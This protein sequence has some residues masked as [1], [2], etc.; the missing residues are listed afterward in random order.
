M[1]EVEVKVRADHEV[2][3]ERLEAEGATQVNRVTQVDTY[4]DAPHKDFA[5][6]D[7]ALRLRHESRYESG[8]VVAEET[9]VTYKGPLV[10]ESS[11]T[12]REYETGVDDGETMGEIFT[13]VGF[14]PAATVEKQRERFVLDEHTISL[15]AVS[16]LG[17]FVEVEIEVESGVDEAREGVFSVLETLGLDPD[18]Q[19][20]TSYLGM[21]LGAPEE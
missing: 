11:K 21:L 13:A 7:E 18:D 20:R 15:D 5:A 17:E 3:R 9:N 19:I 8:T 12:R 4:Y 1:Y 2:V 6:T 14:D 16:G 10:D